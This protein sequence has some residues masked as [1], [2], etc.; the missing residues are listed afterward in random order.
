M[1]VHDD[2]V[3][4]SFLLHCIGPVTLAVT[5]YTTP[6][7]NPSHQLV[8]HLNDTLC[9]VPHTYYVLI[10]GLCSQHCQSSRQEAE[11]SWMP[12]CMYHSTASLTVY[13][14]GN[15]VTAALNTKP[16]C[17]RNTQ[18]RYSIAHASPEPLHP[19]PRAARRQQHGCCQAQQHEP[20]FQ[21]HHQHLQAWWTC[22]ILYAQ[23]P[24]CAIHNVQLSY[25][26]LPREPD[27]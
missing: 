6:E 24:T 8:P 10:D 23:H 11:G 21:V 19:R 26:R 27:T 25:G 16:Y 7:A 1:Y 4:R 12:T 13:L 18:R 20:A 5:T 3:M 17:V 14:L 2:H 22:Q 15:C 9:M